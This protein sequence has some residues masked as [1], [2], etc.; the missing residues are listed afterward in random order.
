[1]RESSSTNHALSSFARCCVFCTHN[2]EDWADHSLGEETP[3]LLYAD[4]LERMSR[5]QVEPLV[6]FFRSKLGLARDTE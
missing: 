1:M 6:S 4:E 5:G 3:F 2:D